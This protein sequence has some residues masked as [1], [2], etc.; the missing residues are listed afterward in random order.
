MDFTEN[1]IALWALGAIA[2]TCLLAVLVGKLTGRPMVGVLVAVA[3]AALVVSG[4][5]FISMFTS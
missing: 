5:L 4:G 1:A 3:A 2:V